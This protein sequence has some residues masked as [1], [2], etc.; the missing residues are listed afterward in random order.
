MD[1]ALRRARL[2]STGLVVEMIV[3]RGRGAALHTWLNER[4]DLHADF[5]R[6][7]G[8][9]ASTVPPLKAIAL[10]ADADN[11]GGR[12]LGWVTAVELQP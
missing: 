6:A 8:D 5:L 9:E 12:S 7:F 3:A 1:H 2:G 4:R 11:T 10:G